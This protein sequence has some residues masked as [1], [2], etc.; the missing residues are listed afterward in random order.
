MA[1]P[2]CN[3]IY[4][5]GEDPEL[6]MC[7]EITGCL[8]PWCYLLPICVAAITDLIS[9]EQINE[10]RNLNVT[11]MKSSQL[12][13]TLLI[14]RSSYHISANILDLILEHTQTPAN[15]SK[16]LFKKLPDQLFQQC[17][18]GG[19]KSSI[20]AT[21]TFISSGSFLKH[22]PP[23]GIRSSLSVPH[24]CSTHSS[25]TSRRSHSIVN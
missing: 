18:R 21:H 12:I 14:L 19:C 4:C 3:A 9:I 10:V 15:T 17:M 20:L 22:T 24:L 1:P 2:R 11:N 25:Y 16:H 8:S 23:Q 7:L 6:V 5:Q 13:S